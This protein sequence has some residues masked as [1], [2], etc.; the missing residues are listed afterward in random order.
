MSLARNSFY[1]ILNQGLSILSSFG[2]LVIISRAL[3]PSGQGLY[4]LSSM[5]PKISMY[6]MTWGGPVAFIYF[7]NEKKSIRRYILKSFQKFYLILASFAFI[8]AGCF[9]F[10]TKDVFYEGVHVENLIKPLLLIFVM[11]YNSYEGAKL[12]A[13]QRFKRLSF[14][15]LNQPLSL[16]VFVTLGYFLELL[17]I[18]NIVSMFCLSH[19][20]VAIIFTILKLNSSILTA[21]DL[22]RKESG[23][24]RDALK[25]SAF[26]HLSAVAI[27]LTY[28]MDIFFISKYLTPVDIGIYMVSVNISERVWVISES[29]S[30][31]LFARLVVLASDDARTELSLRVN[32]IGALLNL[33]IVLAIGLLGHTF[34]NIFFGPAYISSYNLLVILLP[35]VFVSSVGKLLSR[36]L[37][38]K[39]K[40]KFNTMIS[41]GSLVINFCLNLYLIPLWGVK[42]AACA[43]TLTYVVNGIF[44]YI[45]FV[46]I[47]GLGFF[48][49]LKFRKNDF[50]FIKNIF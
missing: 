50:S 36:D 23:Y 26:S 40:P 38:A 11:F 19:I 5:L 42:G 43:T 27:F 28:R 48:E 7:W 20:V 39:G 6:M 3:G 17:T 29:V 37:D 34:I 49:P 35:G 32:R 44:T 30:K 46:R 45:I 4:S 31:V 47:A 13:L 41:G 25:Y 21:N 15:I 33:L 18:D 8:F 9:V 24:I 2:A 14:I 22:E 12:Q 10:F 1:T 16:F